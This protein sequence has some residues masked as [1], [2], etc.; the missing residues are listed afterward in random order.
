MVRIGFSVIAVLLVAAAALLTWKGNHL[1][2]WAIVGPLVLLGLRDMLQTKH[3]ILRNYPIIGH[4]RY[5]L[6]SIRPE[7]MQYFVETDT[8]GRPINRIHRRLVYQRAKDVNDT[9]AFGTQRDVYET[10]YEWMDHSMFPAHMD[11]DHHPQVRIGGPECT[12]PYNASILN[13]SAMSFGS[14]SDRAVM[15]MNGG[16]K[17]GGFAQNKGRAALHLTT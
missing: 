8:E 16:A 17:A 2:V 5:L 6:E 7:I 12:Q 1:W 13:I 11:H 14:L 3:A 10:G 9:T 4:G 15:A